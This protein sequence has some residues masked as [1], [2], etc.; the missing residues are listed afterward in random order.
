MVA[1]W[2]FSKVKNIYIIKNCIQFLKVLI[3]IRLKHSLSWI[4]IRNNSTTLL[5]FDPQPTRYLSHHRAMENFMVCMVWSGAC[6]LTCCSRWGARRR[7]EVRRRKGTSCT[8]TFLRPVKLL[9][10]NNNSITPHVLSW[11]YAFL[12]DSLNHFLH[13]F[14]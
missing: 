9:T 11:M 2:N 13:S 8:S 3:C 7:R 12:L 5:K 6:P 1:K 14:H 10:N 4:R